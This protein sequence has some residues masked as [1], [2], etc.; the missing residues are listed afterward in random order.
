MCNLVLFLWQLP[1]NIIG[2]KIT[3]SAVAIHDYFL[4]DEVIKVYFVKIFLDLEFV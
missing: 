2:Y 3:R 1:Q 4:R